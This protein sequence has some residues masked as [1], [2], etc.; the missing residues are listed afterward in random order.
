MVVRRQ[1]VKESNFALE[2]YLQ[3]PRRG[4]DLERAM[5][6]QLARN[7]PTIHETRKFIA[8]F[9]YFSV[10]STRLTQPTHSDIPIRSISILSSNLRIHIQSGLFPTAFPSYVFFLSHSCHMVLSFL[11]FWWSQKNILWGRTQKKK[12]H[13]NVTCH[14]VAQP[15]HYPTLCFVDRASYYSLCN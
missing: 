9:R 12:I 7:F 3:T 5:A 8:E 4:V 2:M 6:L 14:L 13:V 15:R 1:R 10:S 11:S